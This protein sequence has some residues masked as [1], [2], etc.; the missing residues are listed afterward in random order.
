MKVVLKIGGS[1]MNYPDDL[2]AL[3]KTVENL[4]KRYRILLIPGGGIFADTVLKTQQA[5]ALSDDAAHWMAIMAQD[6]FG[7]VLADKLTSKSIIARADEFTSSSGP[8]LFVLTP[9]SYVKENDE[10]PHKWDVTSDSIA[11]WIG[12]K[13]RVDFVFL[14]KSVDGLVNPSDK[15]QILPQ[16][17]AN[18]LKNFDTKKVVDMFLSQLVPNFSG[19]LYVV[20]GKQPQRIERILSGQATICTEI[21]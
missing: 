11:L 4:S 16:I 2:S 19:R 12:I 10:L 13:S 14:L 3:L 20:N 8:D 17:E 5:L 1:L 21:I 15:T 9:F 6:Q 7:M 18:E